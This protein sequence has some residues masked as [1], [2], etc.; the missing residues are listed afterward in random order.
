MSGVETVMNMVSMGGVPHLTRFRAPYGE[1]FQ[2]GGGALGAIEGIVGKYAVHIGWG[3]DSSD[4]DHDD[5]GKALGNQYFLNKVQGAV[6]N[7]PGSGSWGII[8]MHGTYPWS[9]GEVKGLL[10]P[11]TGYLPTHKFRVGTVEDAVCWK[12]GKHSWQLIAEINKS[13]RR[14]ELAGV[15]LPLRATAHD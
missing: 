13:E 11:K 5:D 7:G 6:G 4:A 1:P 9:L 14:P 12:Y 3:M 8:L 2:A 15:R 10:N